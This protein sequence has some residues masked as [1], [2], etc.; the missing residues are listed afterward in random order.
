MASSPKIPAR[1]RPR[2]GHDG[3]PAARLLSRS[4]S[5]LRLLA[6]LSLVPLPPPAPARAAA[7][8]DAV[9]NAKLA[10]GDFKD[11]NWEQALI[12]FRLAY[13]AVPSPD[14]LFNMAQ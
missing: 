2:D 3:T 11:G 14:Y 5:I 8:E 6:V 12:H 9:T 4:L 10:E 7:A 1:R 13:E